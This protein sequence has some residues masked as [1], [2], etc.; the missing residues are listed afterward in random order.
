SADPDVRAERLATSQVKLHESPV[1]DHGWG[2]RHAIG[3]V[4]ESSLSEAQPH[5]LEV[6]WRHDLPVARCSLVRRWGVSLDSQ[7]PIAHLARERQDAGESKGFHA[8]QRRH[9]PTQLAVKRCHT[10]GIRVPRS[11]RGE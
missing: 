8:R 10:Y 9:A 4:E 2:C 1:D 5:G 11:G 7:S 6:A 3:L